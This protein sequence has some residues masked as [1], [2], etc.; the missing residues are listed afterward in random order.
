MLKAIV[1]SALTIACANFFVINPVV[2]KTVTGCQP[3]TDPLGCSGKG[4][5][6]TLALE[7]V[8]DIPWCKIGQTPK[9]DKCRNGSESGGLYLA[10]K[11]SESE[12]NSRGDSRGEK[13]PPSKSKSNKKDEPIC[14]Y[15]DGKEAPCFGEPSGTKSGS[16][17]FV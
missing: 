7:G 2:A 10:D 9:K 8:P 16:T 4:A 12:K 6:L 13:R 14:Y 11:S 5:P 1:T 3:K 17:R 15:D